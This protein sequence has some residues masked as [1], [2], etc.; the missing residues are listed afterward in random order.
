[1][2]RF[3]PLSSAY[4]SVSSRGLRS[5]M[6]SGLSC[7]R[8]PTSLW[9]PDKLIGQITVFDA[10]YP[11]LT[12]FNK[13]LEVNGH[14]ALSVMRCQLLAPTFK[15]INEQIHNCFSLST[16][17][18]SADH[19]CRRLYTTESVAWGMVDPSLGDEYS[20]SSARSDVYDND[21]IQQQA[22]IT[23]HPPGVFKINH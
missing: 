12:P 14:P 4:Q 16:G 6:D 2:A 7:P 20:A 23:T 1:M 21:S 17:L 11:R 15:K 3:P 22:A 13:T 19:R 8:S 9:N 18:T 10:L 5:I